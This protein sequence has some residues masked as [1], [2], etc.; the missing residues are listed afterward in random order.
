MTVSPATL[1]QVL[2][3]AVVAATVAMLLLL[4]LLLLPAQRLATRRRRRRRRRR[5]ASPPFGAT[6]LLPRR[7]R[8]LEL[9]LLRA[10][11]GSPLP[12]LPPCLLLLTGRVLDRLQVLPLHVQGARLVEDSLTQPVALLAHLRQ[13][14]PGCR[15]GFVEVP[16]LVGG[17]LGG[18]L[19][20]EEGASLGLC[21]G[22]GGGEAAAEVADGLWLRGGRGE[23][24]RGEGIS[25]G[26]LLIKMRKH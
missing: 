14:R 2:A 21:E 16:Q 19:Q 8:L 23:G 4:L 24:R 26:I 3:A 1:I 10:E 5:R 18:G 17:G 12:Q 15:V 6:P 7:L 22:R 25:E 9:L 11:R 13:R 20:V